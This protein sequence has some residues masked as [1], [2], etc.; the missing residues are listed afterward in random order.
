MNTLTNRKMTLARHAK[1]DLQANI[2]K[3]VEEAA[4]EPATGQILVRN[5]LVSL[6]PGLAGAIT[7]EDYLIPPLAIGADI[8]AFTVATVIASRSPRFREG[9]MVHLHGGWKEHAVYDAEPAIPEQMRPFKIDPDRAAPETWLAMLGLSGFTAY[10]GINVIAKP[11]K[12]ETVVV[13]AAAGAVGGMAGQ[14]AR[15]AGARTIGIAGGPTKCSYLVERLKFDEAID[16][17]AGA[18]AKS[19][20]RTCSNGI[21]VY[22]E[23]VGGE[24]LEAVWPRLNTFAR[25]PLCGQVSQYSQSDRPAGPNLFE[26]TIKRVQL[27]GFMGLDP[28]H[29]E[30]FA[31]FQRETLSAIERGQLDLNIDVVDGIENAAAAW[32]DL[33][34]GGN[35]GKRLLRISTP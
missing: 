22:F 25:V 10:L 35:M 24:V 16:Y 31:T 14:F 7:G 30:H 5:H 17:R 19:L 13:S 20:D 18:L 34:T 28:H 2:F 12:S 27:T 3:L 33:F 9:D 15:L 6:E 4:P 29:S 1:G 11:Q 32:L 23:N 26:A 21:D 8:P